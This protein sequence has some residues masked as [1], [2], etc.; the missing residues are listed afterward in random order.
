MTSIL[1][2]VVLPERE[3]DG[4][5]RRC[6]AEYL[7]GARERGLRLERVWRSYTGPEQVAVHLLWSLPTPYDFYAMRATAAADPS[8]TAFWSATD[9]LAHARERRVLEE[10][11]CDAG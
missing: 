9:T 2:T 5:L 4:W 3:A 10:V 11:P 7:P 6:R 1:D 8:V